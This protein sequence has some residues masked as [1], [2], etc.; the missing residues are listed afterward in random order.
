MN[1]LEPWYVALSSPLGIALSTNDQENAK[2]K[3]YLARRASN[4]PDLAGLSLV[5][6]KPGE[7]WIVKK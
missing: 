6:A 5:L 1:Y 3:L 7:I 2:Q 4:D